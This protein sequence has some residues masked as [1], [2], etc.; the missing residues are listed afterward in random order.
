MY[1]WPYKCTEGDSIQQIAGPYNA[2]K[3]EMNG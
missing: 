2:P 3:P 1:T